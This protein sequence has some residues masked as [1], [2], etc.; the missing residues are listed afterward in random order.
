M[1]DLP[2][3]NTTILVID[4]MP[5]ILKVLRRQLEHWGYRALTA[6]SGE[7][8]LALAEAHQPDLIL[9]DILMPKMKGRE[10]CTQLKAS[11]KTKDVPIIFLSALGLSDHVRAGLDVGA[12]DYV[13][14]PF[15]PD[16]L[17]ERIKICLLRNLRQKTKRSAP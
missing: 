3:D 8:G 5:A 11:E 15:K 6:E 4:D 1:D 9:L 16:Y 10:V 12:E 17:R 7:E 13:I 2:V 14:K